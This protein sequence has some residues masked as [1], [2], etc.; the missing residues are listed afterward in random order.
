MQIPL[1]IGLAE[2]LQPSVKFVLIHVFLAEVE[3][4]TEFDGLIVAAL[5]CTSSTFS[6]FM[7]NG[8]FARLLL[9]PFPLFCD[10]ALPR[11]T[12][13]TRRAA[14]GCIGRCR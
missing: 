11:I 5:A 14:N 13:W 10:D 9:E 4:K 6:P 2:L 12:T 8:S 7:V 1:F 3:A